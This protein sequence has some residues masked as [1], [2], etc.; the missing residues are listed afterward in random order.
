MRRWA[1]YMR[2]RDR[3][4]DRRCQDDEENDVTSQSGKNREGCD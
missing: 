2:Q 4:R 3:G 1:M